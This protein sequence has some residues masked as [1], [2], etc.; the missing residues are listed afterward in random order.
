[1]K[2][3]LLQKKG[4]N[5]RKFILHS[6]K[7]SIE[8]KTL[9]KINKYEVRLDSVGLD[10]HYQSDNTL[11][12]KIFFIIC[13]VIIVGSIVGFFL[14]DVK[15]ANGWIFNI[16]SWSIVACIAYCYPHQ[17]DICLVGARPI[18]FFT[19]MYQTNKTF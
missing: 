15:E 14:T 12:G 10:I 1:M 9:Q 5:S 13:S 3:E 2:T 7:I 16:V 17:D 6:E 11:P 4:L 8:T 18:W 19:E